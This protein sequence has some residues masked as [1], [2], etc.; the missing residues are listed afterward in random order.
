MTSPSSQDIRAISSSMC[1]RSATVS[2]TVASPAQRGGV[3][4]LRLRRLQRVGA[5]VVVAVVGRGR[6]VVDEVARGAPPSRPPS[7][8]SCRCRRRRPRPAAD[9][10]GPARPGRLEV[11]VRAEGRDDPA[12]PRVVGR[13]A[14]RARTG[15]RTGRRSWPAPRCRTAR[16]AREAG[17]PGGSAARRPGRR[18]CPRSP[19]TAAPTR[20][21][22]PPS[23][24][25]SQYRI[26]VPRNTAQCV[27]NCR[28][29]SR[30]SASGSGPCPDAEGVQRHPAG[31]QQPGDVV[32]RGDEQARPGP[33]TARRRVAAAGRRARAGR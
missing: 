22:C 2:A 15:R 27:H 12:R 5:D 32:V 30:A 33:G 31:V 17:T 25:S 26:G 16:T 6:A 18:S 11:A 23:S 28:H 10:L 1:R 7:R 8:R 29:T 13:A 24:E 3:D 9:Q 14:R 20:R 4:P 19:P 21:R